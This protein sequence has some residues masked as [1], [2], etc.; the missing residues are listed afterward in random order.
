MDSALSLEV[1]AKIE[2][3]RTRLFR[4]A[5]ATYPLLFF[6][7]LDGDIIASL[8]VARVMSPESLLKPVTP[9]QKLTA[10]VLLQLRNYT[11]ALFDIEANYIYGRMYPPGLLPELAGRIRSDVDKIVH[12]SRL[13]VHCSLSDRAKCV[14][15]ALNARIGYWEAEAEAQRRKA[16]TERPIPPP[17]KRLGGLAPIPTPTPSPS[18][19]LALMPPPAQVQNGPPAGSKSVGPSQDRELRQQ[20]KCT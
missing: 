13:D 10:N 20:V 11:Q 18:A 3:D 9:K 6:S 16:R 4:E 1:R 19:P 5:A 14:E 7:L 8:S 17:L 2:Q 15:D 12:E